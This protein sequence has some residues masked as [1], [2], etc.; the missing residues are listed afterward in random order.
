MIMSKKNYTSTWTPELPPVEISETRA[1]A[2]AWIYALKYEPKQ[3]LSLLRPLLS[4]C[5]PHADLET[6][7]A[8]VKHQSPYE[9]IT[10]ELID[11]VLENTHTDGYEVLPWREAVLRVLIIDFLA[12]LKSSS[13]QLIEDSLNSITSVLDP[14]LR[15]TSKNA[16]QTISGQRTHLRKAVRSL[17]LAEL[18]LVH[19]RP[20]LS[21]ETIQDDLMGLVQ[22]CPDIEFITDDFPFENYMDENGDICAR[23]RYAFCEALKIVRNVRKNQDELDTIIQ[24]S[25]KRWRIS[26]MSIVDLNILRLATY[27]LCFE[28]TLSPKILINE[29]VELAKVF[30]ADQSKNFVNGILQQLCNDNQIAVN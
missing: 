19:Y 1:A 29:A 15:G 11:E 3:E 5:F 4:E 28:R 7:A 13:A 26:R 30:G 24:N 2:A 6:V 21:D 18:Y 16:S 22:S 17:V 8:M 14:K 25:S 20:E 23:G 9:D 27:E 10:D 12:N